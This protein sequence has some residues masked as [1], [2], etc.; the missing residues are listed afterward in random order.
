M[1]INKYATKCFLP[2]SKEFSHWKKTNI[3]HDTKRSVG[4][5]FKGALDVSVQCLI[6][7]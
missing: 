2:C 3:E 4:N 7:M 5:H 1:H 6:Y